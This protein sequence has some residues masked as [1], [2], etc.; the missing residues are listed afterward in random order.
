MISNESS[1]GKTIFAYPHSLGK[2]FIEEQMQRPGKFSTKIIVSLLPSLILI[3]S[4]LV[5]NTPNATALQLGEC[6]ITSSSRIFA[7]SS[8]PN[9]NRVSTTNIEDPEI[10][11]DSHVAVSVSEFSS[12]GAPFFGEAVFYVSDVAPYDGGFLLRI[13][14]N[15]RITTV[16]L[17]YKIFYTAFTGDCK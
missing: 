16:P 10:T 4:V 3:A 13:E 12:E 7:T 8:N 11:P 9:V 1:Q 14:V 6:N 17:Q 2:S 5:V 15:T